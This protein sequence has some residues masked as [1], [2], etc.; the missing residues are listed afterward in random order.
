MDPVNVSGLTDTK[1][2]ELKIQKPS[3]D[4]VL[5]NDTVLVTVEIGPA[6]SDE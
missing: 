2:F 3:S 4:A 6:D 1:V 5:S